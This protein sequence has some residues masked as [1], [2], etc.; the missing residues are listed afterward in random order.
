MAQKKK[1][2][3]F[4]M[5]IDETRTQVQQRQEHRL[6]RYNSGRGRDD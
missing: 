3:R 2:T 5:V 4:G 6:S 1:A